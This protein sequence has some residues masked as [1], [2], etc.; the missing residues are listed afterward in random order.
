MKIKINLF[1]K[2]FLLSLLAFSVIAAIIITSLYL[3]KNSID[4]QNK[5]SNVLIGV[6]EKDKII[7]LCV[8]NFNPKG[9]AINFLPIPDNV[10][11]DSGIVLQDL[12]NKNNIS[13]LEKS[14]E[15]LIGTKINR[16]LLLNI[17]TV[18]K[19]NNQM[20]IFD[21][22]VQ[23]PFEYNNQTK[24]GY[25][26]INGELVKA[27]FTYKGYD[28]LSVSLSSIGLSYLNT[29]I[30]TYTK[31]QHI[32]RLMQIMSSNDIINDSHTNLDKK[33]ITSYVEFLSK[34]DQLTQNTIELLGTYNQAS[35]STY[36]IPENTKSDKN[37]F[38]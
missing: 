26:Q 11:I 6:T 16:Y 36:F 32:Q 21:Y 18:A 19:I 31:P 20:G 15:E 33:E 29:F 5:E 13:Q 12:Y 35:S 37:I 3:D 24:S 1:N 27:M 7:S 17:D 25:I 23:F 28:L 38:K 34:Y 22:P 9:N 30:S 8:I 2:S 4:P 10:W 14:I